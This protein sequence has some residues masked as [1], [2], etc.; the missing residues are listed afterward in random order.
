MKKILFAALLA[1]SAFKACQNLQSKLVCGSFDPTTAI[2]CD[3]YTSTTCDIGGYWDCLAGNFK[4]VNNYGDTSGWS[5][6]QDLA[7]CK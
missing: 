7:A 5:F 4:C 6:C 3:L 2:N 1:L